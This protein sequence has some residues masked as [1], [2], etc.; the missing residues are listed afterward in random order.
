MN[1]TLREIPAPLKEAIKE[2]L[3]L[4]KEKKFPMGKVHYISQEGWTEEV[5]KKVGKYL[6]QKGFRTEVYMCPMFENWQVRITRPQPSP[7]RQAV[8]EYG[9]TVRAASC[10]ATLS[11]E[12][13][14][15]RLYNLAEMVSLA[16]DTLRREALKEYRRK[17]KA[18]DPDWKPEEGELGHSYS[19]D[20][21][22]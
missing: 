6:E 16:V 8:L 19:V 17:R 11:R 12:L 22:F 9:K 15:R 2:V 18:I 7:A 14:E 5:I 1:V 13:R 20:K 4:R 21:F 3:T 10:S